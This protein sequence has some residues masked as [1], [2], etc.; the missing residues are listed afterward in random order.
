MDRTKLCS[1]MD[2]ERSRFAEGFIR[3]V[4]NCIGLVGIVRVCFLVSPFFTALALIWIADDDGTADNSSK[5]PR[6]VVIEN[7]KVSGF[8][9]ELAGINSVS[10]TFL[11]KENTDLTDTLF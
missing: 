7:V 9:S 2:G 3:I 10:Y 4:G 5:S 11:P 8:T 1:I 6:K